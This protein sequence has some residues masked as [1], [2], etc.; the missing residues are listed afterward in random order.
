MS[1]QKIHHADGF[2]VIAGIEG[3]QN[4]RKKLKT[5]YT[6]LKEKNDKMLLSV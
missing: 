5:V 2:I 6:R 4:D 1:V 3:F